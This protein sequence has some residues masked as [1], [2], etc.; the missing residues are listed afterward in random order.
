MLEKSQRKVD[1]GEVSINS[2]QLCPLL[3]KNVG[4][5]QAPQKISIWKQ[6]Q[7]EEEETKKGLFLR[8]FTK[9]NNVKLPTTH[10]ICNHSKKTAA[11]HQ[12]LGDEIND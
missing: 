8:T 11:M 3:W 6:L 10:T 1:G 4:W 2:T 12:L 9:Q 5:N 7:D